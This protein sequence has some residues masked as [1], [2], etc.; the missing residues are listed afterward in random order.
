MVAYPSHDMMA[1]T[2]ALAG[3]VLAGVTIAVAPE[4]TSV[5]LLMA[6]VGG[7]FPDLDL[8]SA[9]RKTLHYPVYYSMLAVVSG[10][11]AVLLPTTLT[12]GVGFFFLAA[13]LHSLMDVFGGGLELRPWREQSDRAVYDHYRNRWITPRRWVRYDGA[14]EDLLLAVVFGSIAAVLYPTTADTAIVVAVA[15]S[16]VY[17]LLR[18]PLV[19]LTEWAVRSLPEHLLARV[20]ERFVEDFSR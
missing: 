11:F 17:A 5:A 7:V 10:I 20:P 16:T 12:V 4:Y 19:N 6:A 18:K 9:H 8:Y 1:T 13:A 15:I 14:P 2:H 3:M